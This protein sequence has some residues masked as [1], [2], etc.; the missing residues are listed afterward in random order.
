M[1]SDGRNVPEA[2]HTAFKMRDV[3]YDAGVG[4]ELLQRGDLRADVAASTL[5]QRLHSRQARHASRW[6]EPRRRAHCERATA[7]AA[8]LPSRSE[9]ARPAD[10]VAKF[11]RTPEEREDEAITAP[12]MSRAVD[13]PP[14]HDREGTCLRVA[15]RRGAVRTPATVERH[16][17]EGLGEPRRRTMSGASERPGEAEGARDGVLMIGVELRWVST[18][19]PLRARPAIAWRTARPGRGR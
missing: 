2:T 19:R 1:E 3:H 9:V 16:G 13:A 12:P 11:T 8:R 6:Q 17:E 10:L 14:P 7:A 18:L 4:D 5:S 15:P